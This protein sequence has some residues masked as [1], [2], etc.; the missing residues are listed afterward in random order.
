MKADSYPLKRVKTKVNLKMI[1]RFV[2]ILPAIP[3]Q[4]MKAIDVIVD[5]GLVLEAGQKVITDEVDDPEVPSRMASV[6]Q[7][8]QKMSE[9]RRNR[10][11]I[12][13]GSVKR[14]RGREMIMKVHK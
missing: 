14:R 13:K 8:I 7:P 3:H 10:E 2:G 9:E 5:E 1:E 6:T 11:I 4:A 12:S